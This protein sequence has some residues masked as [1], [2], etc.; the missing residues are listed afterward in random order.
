MKELLMRNGAN[1]SPVGAYEQSDFIDARVLAANT[2]ESHTIP[3]GAKFVR[4]AADVAVYVRVGGTAAV[5]AADVTDGS[6]SELLTPNMP[7]MLLSLGSATAI[8]LIAGATAHVTLAFY[9]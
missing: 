7:P 2:A 8:G 1:S 9:K 3:T 5:P 6:A 4:V